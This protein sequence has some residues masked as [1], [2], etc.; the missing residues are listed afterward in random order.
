MSISGVVQTQSYGKF[1][2]LFLS[3]GQSAPSVFLG[4]VNSYNAFSG[5]QTICVG[6]CAP[7]SGSNDVL[8]GGGTS[9]SSGFDNTIVGEASGNSISTN[10]RNSI[11]GS[12]AGNGISG[13]ENS[14][15]GYS[16]GPGVTGSDNSIFGDQAGNNLTSGIFN[17][18][19]GAVSCVGLVS[20]SSNTV[21]GSGDGTLNTNIGD[22]GLV[23]VGYGAND[24]GSA[25]SLT[26]AV[27]I[28]YK[29]T[30]ISS[31]TMQLGGSGA[32]ALVVNA[33]TITVSSIT[34]SK[35]LSVVS[36]NETVAISTNGYIGYVGGT[37][38]TFT[39]CGTTPTV[40]A[41]S[42]NMR[43]AVTMTAGLSSSCTIVPSSPVPLNYFCTISGGG[44]GTAIFFQQ[45]GNLTGACDNATGLVTCGIG[46]FM[47]WH[48][49]GTN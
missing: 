23:L 10:R 40:T 45:S 33:S 48:C 13:D 49:T 4:S 42:N 32:N 47:T 17:A 44:A 37:A 15:F 1:G 36:S 14:I 35:Q 38:P 8:I 12:S 26:N 16:A 30:V 21:M 11:F 18:C 7:T 6:G 9:V 5:G 20:G 19:F 27:A 34:I 25:G 41:G 3:D 29:S 43:G 22:G 39:G 24:T 28:G 31:N 46:T 2:S